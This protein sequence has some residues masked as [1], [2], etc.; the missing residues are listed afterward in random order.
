MFGFMIVM[1]TVFCIVFLLA[2]AVISFSG[3]NIRELVFFGVLTLFYAILA[4]EYTIREDIWE[5]SLE[6]SNILSEIE[7][8]KKESTF[9]E[10]RVDYT[11]CDVV[12]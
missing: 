10:Q 8:L 11:S 7:E 5:L 6:V 9:I 12:Q 1:F 3:V 4:T 2:F